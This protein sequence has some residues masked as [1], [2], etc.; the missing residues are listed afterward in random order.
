MIIFYGK[1]V[2]YYD[3]QLFRIFIK[4]KGTGRLIELKSSVL[5]NGGENKCLVFIVHFARNFMITQNLSVI[6]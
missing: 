5:K 2:I 1:R 3:S 4:S 6:L